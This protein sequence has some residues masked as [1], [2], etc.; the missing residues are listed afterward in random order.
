MRQIQALRKGAG[1]TPKDRIKVYYSENKE[2]VEKYKEQI[3]KQVI[4]E[5]IE[6]KEGNLEIK[7]SW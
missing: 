5:S 2:I 3:K 6:F 4:A 1:L 7:K